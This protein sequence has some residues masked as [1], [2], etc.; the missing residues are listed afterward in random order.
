[1]DEQ[2]IAESQEKIKELLDGE[3]PVFIYNITN[4]ESWSAAFK[5]FF[6]GLFSLLVTGITFGILFDAAGC[7]DLVRIIHGP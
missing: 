4:Q 1:M 2:R 3:K 5:E 7:I 6:K